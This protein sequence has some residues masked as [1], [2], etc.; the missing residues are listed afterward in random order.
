ML[1]W[2][3]C[4]NK[5]KVELELLRDVDLLLKVEKGI[6]DGMCHAIY[7]RTKVN[8]KYMRDYETNKELS[9][10]MDWDVNNFYG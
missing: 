9:Y 5:G 2:Q 7:Q 1:L 4:L 10:F 3:I 6:R 8:N